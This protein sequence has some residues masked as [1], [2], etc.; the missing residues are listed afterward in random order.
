M[1]AADVR[2]LPLLEEGMLSGPAELL[3]WQRA[4]PRRDGEG[5][6]AA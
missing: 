2:A 5:W 1:A 4:S 6:V 3:W